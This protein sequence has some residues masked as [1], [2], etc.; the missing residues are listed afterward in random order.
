MNTRSIFIGVFLIIVSLVLVACTP[1]QPSVPSQIVCNTP[2]ILVGNECCL[3]KDSNA[4]CDRDEVK[5]PIEEPAKPE[6]PV[7]VPAA[8]RCDELDFELK[9]ACSVGTAVQYFIIVGDV[10]ISNFTLEVVHNIEG[11]SSETS[12]FKSVRGG[13]ENSIVTGQVRLDPRIISKVFVTS[14]PCNVT[15]SFGPGFPGLLPAC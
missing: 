15:K 11:S 13:L 9:N 5:A 1:T 3:D 7:V 8:E 14:S 4:I 6:T 2:Y 12:T 10:P